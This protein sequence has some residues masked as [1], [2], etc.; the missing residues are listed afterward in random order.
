[1]KSKLAMSIL[2]A[3]GLSALAPAA[4]M[5]AGVHVAPVKK[6]VRENVEPWLADPTIIGAVKEQNAKTASLDGA[7]IDKLDR[8]WRAQATAIKRPFVDEVLSRP[9]SKFLKG[10]QEASKGRITEIFLMDA[11][12]LNVGQ[13]EVTSD[14]WQGDEAAWQRS[15]GDGPGA[16]FVDTVKTDDSTRTRQSQASLTIVDPASGQAIGAITIGINLDKL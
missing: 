14:Y 3:V 11:K 2:V 1:M 13:S 7:A 16:F 6:F 10:K 12:G 8:E 9:V 5:A 4:A 15:F